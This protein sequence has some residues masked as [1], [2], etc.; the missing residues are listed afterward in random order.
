MSIA[1]R[2]KELP[3]KDDKVIDIQF[4]Y[5]IDMATIFFASGKRLIVNIYDD[6]YSRKDYM[7]QVSI[8]NKEITRKNKIN[9]I[10]KDE[11]S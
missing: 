5:G 10:L 3:F 6:G 1:N 7:E 2:I 9:N 8:N 11:R 4:S